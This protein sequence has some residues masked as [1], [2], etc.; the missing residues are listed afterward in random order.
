MRNLKRLARDPAAWTL[1]ACIVSVVGLATYYARAY[2]W[3]VVDDALI[4]FQYAKNWALGRGVVFNSG[5]RV[6]G[7]TN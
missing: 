6:E 2:H 3:N 5:E 1:V 7:Y 4:S